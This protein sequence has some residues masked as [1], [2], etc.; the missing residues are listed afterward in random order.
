MEQMEKLKNFLAEDS[1]ATVI[2][3]AF[4]ASMIA[5]A[6][7]VGMNSVGTSLSTTFND[8]AGSL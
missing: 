6:T 5:M 2:E 3:Y 1:G 8:V 4:L 7:L